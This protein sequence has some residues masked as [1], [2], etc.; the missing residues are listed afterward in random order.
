MGFSCVF[1]TRISKATNFWNAPRINSGTVFFLD[2]R[3]TGASLVTPVQ[4]NRVLFTQKTSAAFESCLM[5]REKKHNNGAFETKRSYMWIKLW[6]HNRRFEF[7]AQ[8]VPTNKAPKYF[9]HWNDHKI[10]FRFDDISVCLQ[11]PVTL[12]FPRHIR[13]SAALH[14]E[15]ISSHNVLVVFAAAFGR[16]CQFWKRDRKMNNCCGYVCTLWRGGGS[17][18]LSLTVICSSTRRS[19]EQNHFQK[20][21]SIKKT[22]ISYFGLGFK[23]F[24]SLVTWITSSSVALLTAVATSLTS[25]LTSLCEVSCSCSARDD[26]WQ[27]CSFSSSWFN[28]HCREKYTKRTIISRWLQSCTLYM[29]MNDNWEDIRWQFS[30][31][32]FTR[33]FTDKLALVGC[34]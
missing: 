1:V 7:W 25:M 12:F 11:L 20:E 19:F 34:T 23:R 2:I 13:V 27:K 21:L 16:M 5:W 30:N 15:H 4:R 24:Y 8:A 33:R 32:D 3:Y 6:C 18:K 28:K 26:S 29:Y 14:V 22:L 31:N 10:T 9:T 17:Y